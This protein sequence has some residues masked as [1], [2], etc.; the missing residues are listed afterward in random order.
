MRR[1]R[2]RGAS[3]AATAWRRAATMTRAH[4][5]SRIG[6]AGAAPAPPGAPA[7]PPYPERPE[8][9]EPRSGRPHDRGVAQL[10]AASTA[11]RPALGVPRS[12]VPK[13][14]RWPA[15]RRLTDPHI[16]LAG[17]DDRVPDA[18][19]H[20]PD[21]LNTTVA[22][23]GRVRTRRCGCPWWGAGSAQTPPEFPT[24]LPP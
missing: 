20:P 16:A 21:G 24:L 17:L 10:R 1:G 4:A 9:P 19:P 14:L 11:Q 7:V 13:T 22:S 15:M 6:S 23:G 18:C 8:T 12:W 2:D 5:P 3:E